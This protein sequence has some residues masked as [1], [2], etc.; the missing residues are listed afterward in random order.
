MADICQ[1]VTITMITTKQNLQFLVGIYL[2]PDIFQI[3][4]IQNGRLE[5]IID[6]NMCHIDDW[7]KTKSVVSVKDIPLKMST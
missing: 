7:Y 5:A 3:D 4:Q 6:F 1:F 2:C